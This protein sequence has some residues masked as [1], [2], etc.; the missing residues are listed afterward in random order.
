M[1]CDKNKSLSNDKV[2]ISLERDFKCSCMLVKGVIQARITL[3]FPHT[4]PDS[5]L[6]EFR[7][8]C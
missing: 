5:Y 8:P 1:S 7:Y 2:L 4:D 3:A 6:N